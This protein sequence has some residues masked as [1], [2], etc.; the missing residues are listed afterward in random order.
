[1]VARMEALVRGATRVPLSGKAL[2]DV[3]EALMLIQAMRDT[4]PDEIRSATR[5]TGERSQILEEARL[6]AERIVRDAKQY[7]TQLTDELAVTREAQF[8]AEETIERAKAVARQIRG[9]ATGYAESVLDRMQRT[10]QGM[11]EDLEASRSEL[12]QWDSTRK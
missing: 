8:Q 2:V 3:E 6:E 10:L 5:L 1:M 11:A 12:K 7:A 4:L 9:G